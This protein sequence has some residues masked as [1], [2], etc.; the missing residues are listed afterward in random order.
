M[1]N[2]KYGN[3][4]VNLYKYQDTT[5]SVTPKSIIPRHNYPNSNSVHFPDITGHIPK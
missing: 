4:P 1:N 2:Q 3:K 5:P